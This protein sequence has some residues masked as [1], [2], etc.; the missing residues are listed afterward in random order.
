ML[1]SAVLITF[2]SARVLAEVLTAL[3][4]C[5]EIVVV[6]SGSQDE[7]LTIAAHFGCRIIHQP[8][9]GF[10]PQKRFAV[11]QARYDW[12]LVVDADEVV[13]PPL[14]R[15]IRELLTRPDLPAGFSVPVSLV[16]L[17]RLM[18]GGE[19]KRPQRRL[20]D[21]RRGNFNA[22]MVHED[23]IL[24]DP[25]PCLHH[26]MLHYSY[27]SLDE[28]FEK[29]NRYTT[30]GARQMLERGRKAP[31]WQMTLRFPF[32]FVREYVVKLNFLNGYPGFVWALFSAVYPVVKYAKLREL[33]DKQAHP[34]KSLTP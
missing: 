20:F 5:D 14:A 34:Q 22:N 30:I 11:G 3:H 4:W 24:P 2:N 17:G 23:V 33:L 6:D 7:T 28:Y 10:G 1:L 27:G 8:F 15:E 31:V 19:F 29:F 26:Y 9:L 12:V 18:R 16:F 13:T 21:R 25:V 32:T